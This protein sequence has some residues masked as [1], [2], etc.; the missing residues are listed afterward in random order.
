[1]KALAHGVPVLV[2]PVN[3][4]SDQ[5]LIA[6][7]IEE[8]GVGMSVRKSANPLAICAA[9]QRLLADAELQECAANMGRRMRSRPAGAEVASEQILAILGENGAHAH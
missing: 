9:V 3:P 7:V 4:L 5:P 1:M 8:S 2:I 6:R